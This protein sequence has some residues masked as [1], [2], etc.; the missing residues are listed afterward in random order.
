ME[1]ARLSPIGGENEHEKYSMR[2]GTTHRP[3]NMGQCFIT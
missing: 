2:R 3:T 1:L